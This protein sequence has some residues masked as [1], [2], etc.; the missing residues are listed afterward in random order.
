M[1]G[2]VPPDGCPDCG[3]R[4]RPIKLFGR[5][6]ENP[7]SGVAIETAIAHYTYP[8]AE[9][10]LLSGKFKPAGSVHAFLCTECRRVYLYGTP[11]PGRRRPAT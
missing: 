6:W 9:R 7:I 2:H 8:D 1:A 3:G 5:G 4:L 11:R 10:S